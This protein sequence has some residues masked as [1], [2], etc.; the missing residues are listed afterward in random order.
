[1]GD[2]LPSVL[3]S[4]MLSLLDGP[5]VGP[6][7]HIVREL[8]IQKLP[9]NIQYQLALVDPTCSLSEL[10]VHADRIVKAETLTTQ[11]APFP[12]STAP[13]LTL[14]QGPPIP[15]SPQAQGLVQA[16]Q[17][18]PSQHVSQARI[19]FLEQSILDL[20]TRLRSLETLI[21][22]NFYHAPS[23]NMDFSAHRPRYFNQPRRYFKSPHASRQ[24]FH[25]SQS[26]SRSAQQ[27]PS[28]LAH[29]SSVPSPSDSQGICLNHQRF[30]AHTRN[31]HKPCAFSLN[32]TATS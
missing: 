21:H 12:A 10:A 15:S 7:I 26:P 5:P 28:A 9:S 25:H 17:P 29:P 1:M 16:V 2:R 11:L 32:D 19:T 27:P 3:L 22:P 14:G 13:A 31:C 20:Q 6:C 23:P 8:F 30:G 18:S 24:S 4:N